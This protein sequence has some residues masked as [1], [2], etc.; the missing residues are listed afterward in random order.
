[1]RSRGGSIIGAGVL[2]V[3]GSLFGHCAAFAQAPAPVD[4]HYELYAAG[5]HVADVQTGFVL[6]P[7]TYQMHLAYHT[8]GLASL[9][10]HGN[11]DSVANGIWYGNS[12]APQRFLA[13]GSQK[14][15]PRLTDIEFAGGMPVVRRLVP[16]DANERQPVPEALKDGSVDMLSAMSDLMHIAARTGGCDR[17]LRTYDGHR[18]LRL[19]SHTMGQEMLTPNHGSQF[20]GSALRCDF[21]SVPIA[22]AKIG[23]AADARPFR[24]SIWLASPFA[25]A[26]NMPVRMAFQ[27]RWFGEAVM[28]LMSAQSASSTMM[29]GTR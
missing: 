14:G 28:Y 16:A 29:A 18:V 4:A 22:G 27:T 11:S 10:A 15:N 5:L 17:E 23:D 24:G 6:G 21:S 3:F 1:M 12:V 8:T 9:F 7:N 25:A 2:G 19:D 20:N 13:E 26:P